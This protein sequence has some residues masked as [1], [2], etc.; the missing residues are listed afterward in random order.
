LAYVDWYKELI[1]PVADIGMHQVSLS[2]RNHRQNSEIIPITDIVRSCHLIP[3]FGR[4]VDLTWTS[5]HVLDQCKSF[6]LNPYL[7]HH[8]FFFFR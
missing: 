1:Q 6:Y 2:S 7:R 8:D 3:V 5:E 4:S